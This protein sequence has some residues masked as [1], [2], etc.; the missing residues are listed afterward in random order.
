MRDSF[1]VAGTSVEEAI[2]AM[3]LRLLRTIN[4]TERGYRR[5]RKFL[6]NNN[7]TRGEKEKEESSTGN[8]ARSREPSME[9]D[10]R[11][12]GF[13][14]NP[15]TIGDYTNSFSRENATTS[16]MN[17]SIDKEEGVPMN[18]QLQ[19]GMSGPVSVL[20]SQ[21]PSTCKAAVKDDRRGKEKRDL[22]E[23]SLFNYERGVTQIQVRRFQAIAALALYQLAFTRCT[24]AGRRVL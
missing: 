10:H 3:I 18:H 9:P 17:R 19:V 8:S 24:G 4:Q 1:C 16:Q 14:T 2:D 11:S 23:T 15:A 21:S 5:T 20:S 7:K 13:K 22:G 6:T 12:G